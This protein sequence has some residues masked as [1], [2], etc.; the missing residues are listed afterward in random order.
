ML[1]LRLML[2]AD[3]P[4]I[5]VLPMAPSITAALHTVTS[6]ILRE[7]TVASLLILVATRRKEPG[8]PVA[9]QATFAPLH[10]GRVCHGQE[11][12]TEHMQLHSNG[13]FAPPAH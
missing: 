9:A 1:V 13:L 5:I 11:Q 12:G 4:S 10:Y 7:R 8:M 6:I 3:S 2:G